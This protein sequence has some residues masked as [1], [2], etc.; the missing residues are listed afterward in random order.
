MIAG[1]GF[2]LDSPVARVL[3]CVTAAD[4]MVAASGSH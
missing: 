3:S 4:A 1:P 2:V